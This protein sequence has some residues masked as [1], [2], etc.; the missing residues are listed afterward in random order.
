MPESTQKVWLIDLRATVMVD[1]SDE[2]GARKAWESGSEYDLEIDTEG[3]IL[4]IEQLDDYKP[5]PEELHGLPDRQVAAAECAG[6]LLSDSSER[7]DCIERLLEIYTCNSP[8][9]WFSVALECARGTSHVYFAALIADTR[10]DARLLEAL[11]EL[12]EE[13]YER[14]GQEG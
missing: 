10:N 12:A 11:R 1:A 2:P 3:G 4:R 14:D 9:A 13:L 7:E 5:R 8:D 6:Y